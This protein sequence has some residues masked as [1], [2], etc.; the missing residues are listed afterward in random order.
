V[1]SNGH[2]RPAGAALVLAVV[3]ICLAAIAWWFTTQPVCPSAQG[4]PNGGYRTAAWIIAALALLASGRLLL[5][6]AGHER[7]PGTRRV[8]FGIVVLLASWYCLGAYGCLAAT[9]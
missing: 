6:V 3:A 8:L 9:A 4:F 1:T 2:K 7:K 5:E